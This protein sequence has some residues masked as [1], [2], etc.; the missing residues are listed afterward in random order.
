MRVK[1]TFGTENYEENLTFLENGLFPANLEGKKRKTIRDYFLK[2]FYDNHIK[3]YK[4]R[5][6][7]WL[8]SSP[9]GTFNALIYLH[10]YRSDTVS[11]VLSYLRDF[12]AK[13]TAQMEHLQRVADSGGS[14]QKEKA[15]AL[16]EINNLKKELK[17]IEDYERDTLYPLATAQVELDLDDGVKVNYNKLGKALK[18][19]TGLS[20]K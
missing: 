18:K 7:Y 19:V 13:L 5:P 3:L 14:S 15:K 11:V 10:R 9:K 1:V 16:K 8:F 12:Q 6:I 4:K 2:G 17:E 20:G